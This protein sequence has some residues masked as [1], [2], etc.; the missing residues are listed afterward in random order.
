QHSCLAY[1]EQR[2]QLLLSKSAERS[3]VRPGPVDQMI[4]FAQ[5]LTAPEIDST[6]MVE[7]SDRVDPT[8]LEQVDFVPGAHVAVGKQN[9]AWAQEIPQPAQHTQLAVALAGIAADSEVEYGSA[10]ERKEGR[11]ACQRKTTSWRLLRRL[12]TGLLVIRGIWH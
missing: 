8:L 12:R 6:A 2:W 3:D 9:V 5:T 4:T 11:D 1:G 10:G 7:T